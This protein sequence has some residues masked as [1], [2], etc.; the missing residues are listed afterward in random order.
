[1]ASRSMDILTCTRCGSRQTQ[2]ARIARAAGISWT[3][4]LTRSV[5]LTGGLWRGGRVGG[6]G[7]WSSTEE[8]ASVSETRGGVADIVELPDPPTLRGV[9]RDVIKRLRALRASNEW[10]SA[11]ACF[12]SWYGLV[13]ID[14]VR[15]YAH[16]DAEFERRL[17]LHELLRQNW[18]RLMLCLQCGSI[19]DPYLYDELVAEGRRLYEAGERCTGSQ[20][21]DE[22]L[23]DY[24]D[25]VRD[26]ESRLLRGDDPGDA[27][28]LMHRLSAAVPLR[29]LGPA[30]RGGQVSPVVHARVF[31]VANR[32]LIAVIEGYARRYRES[33]SVVLRAVETAFL[34]EGSRAPL[35]LKLDA[36][37]AVVEQALYKVRRDFEAVGLTEQIDA[38]LS[39]FDH[40]SKIID[41]VILVGPVAVKYRALTSARRVGHETHH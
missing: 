35:L 6:G 22:T 4:Q 31:Q 34:D 37:E 11:R 28:T 26:I 16:A 41:D 19:Y 24:E 29:D 14:R 39:A 30:V 9:R 18:S 8:T 10:R 27:T 25:R 33:I 1:M 38:D 21:L 36:A 40:A 13:F 15:A 3:R 23:T 12:R 32:L 5:S 2:S 7:A 17:R 20:H